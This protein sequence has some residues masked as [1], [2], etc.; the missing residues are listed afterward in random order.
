M[1]MMLAYFHCNR[2][3]GSIFLHIFFWAA[4]FFPHR[5]LKLPDV[6]F[7]NPILRTRQTNHTS[8]FKKKKSS[9]KAGK[10][11]YLWSQLEEEVYFE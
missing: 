10:L 11:N 1:P 6:P 3:A 9:T 7:D 2:K 8:L 5:L 4:L